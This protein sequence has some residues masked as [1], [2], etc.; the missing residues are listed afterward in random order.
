MR[1][2]A[3]MI[4]YNIIAMCV[5]VCI[6]YTCIYMTEVMMMLGKKWDEGF[7]CITEQWRA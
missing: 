2:N 3:S 5:Y 7:A 4:V 6:E 1:S